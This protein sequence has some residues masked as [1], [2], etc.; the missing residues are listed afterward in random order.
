[1]TLCRTITTAGTAAAVASLLLGGSA[2]ASTPAA[3]PAKAVV[4]K[5][6]KHKKAK[7]NKKAKSRK[8]HRTH[9]M[10]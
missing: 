3:T 8:A 9:W 6:K 5:A 10:K 7:K 1:M 4:T 2:M